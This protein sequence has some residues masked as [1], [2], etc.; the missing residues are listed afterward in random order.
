MWV[1]SPLMPSNVRPLGWRV[2]SATVSTA[3]PVTVDKRFR[4][5]PEDASRYVFRFLQRG[6]LV[7][8]TNCERLS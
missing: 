6:K 5:A 3:L 2:A 1:R 7:R 8:I 4:A